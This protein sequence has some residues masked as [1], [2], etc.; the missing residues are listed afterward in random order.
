MKQLLLVIAIL[1]FPLTAI[2]ESTPP[3]ATAPV[4]P[5]VTSPTIGIG[6]IDV[7]RLVSESEAGKSI[8][9]QLD[10][11][12]KSLESEA[13]TLEKSLL[14]EENSI[15]AQQGK[16]PPA[17]FEAKSKAYQTKLDG[18]RQ[19]LQ[20]KQANLEKLRVNALS[21]LQQHIAKIS[22]NIADQKKLRV[23]I[24]RAS[25]VIV[26]QNLDVTSEALKQLN[27]SVKSIKVGG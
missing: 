5:T 9:T 3:A 6:V 24:D 19:S 12:G 16:I 21:Q 4:T 11:R 8:M 26:E 1:L 7:M 27:A 2:A 20:T 13:S 25:V 17:E 18:V 15:L 14:A 23:I 22:A 10:A